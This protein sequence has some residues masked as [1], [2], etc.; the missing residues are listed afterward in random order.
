MGPWK[1]CGAAHVQGG[2]GLALEEG[3]GDTLKAWSVM[4]PLLWGRV[5]QQP[6]HQEHKKETKVSGLGIKGTRPTGRCLGFRKAHLEPRGLSH[7]EM[8]EVP[9]QSQSN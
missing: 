1:G 5:F 4:Q 2:W 3:E 8:R 7:L 6:S 9:D